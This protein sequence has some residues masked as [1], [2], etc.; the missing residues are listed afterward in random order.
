MNKEANNFSKKQII[1]FFTVFFLAIYWSKSTC[2]KWSFP[3]EQIRTKLRIYSHLL[4]K[5]LT[6]NLT[7]CVLNIIGF[8]T[9]YCKF[10]FKP[11]YSLL[12]TLN[13][14]TLETE[15]YPVSFEEINFWHKQSI[16]LLS[17]WLVL[18]ILVISTWLVLWLVIFIWFN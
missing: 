10:F 6:E 4:N 18:T 11:D 8:T 5:S 9:E 1:F 17:G 15:K 12:C 13:Q 3:L 2:K 14:S 7:F 16:I